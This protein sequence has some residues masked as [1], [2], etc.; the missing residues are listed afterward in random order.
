MG[1]ITDEIRSLLDEVARNENFTNFEL[2]YSSGSE[3]GDGFLSEIAKVQICGN[4]KMENGEVATDQL[5]LVCKMA[6]PE[7]SQREQLNSDQFFERETYFY[8]EIAPLFMEF[9]R[10]RGLT[11]DEMFTAFPKCYKAVN[12]PEKN[13]SVIILEDLRPQGFSMWQKG[14]VA[15][16]ENTRSIVRELAKLHAISFAMRDQYPHKFSKFESLVDLWPTFLDPGA[17][18]NISMKN[19]HRVIKMLDKPEHKKIYETFVKDIKNY[20]IACS[21]DKIPKKFRVI[22]HGDAWMNNIL[23]KT[24]KVSLI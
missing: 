22:N 4:R 9:Q 2:R 19:F 16:I 1:E 6:F 7:K 12:D 18:Y 3:K 23:F 8:N 13:L 20:Y 17:I 10:E 15:K 21:D 24:D 11:E 5:D 14:R